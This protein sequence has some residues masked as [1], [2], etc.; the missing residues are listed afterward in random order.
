MSIRQSPSLALAL[1]ALSTGQLVAATQETVHVRVSIEAPHYGVLSDE[2]RAGVE[3]RLADTLIAL[4]RGQYPFLEWTSAPP[5]VPRLDVRL[6][7]DT[8]V[9]PPA[10]CHP[11]LDLRFVATT[12]SGVEN[13]LENAARGVVLFEACDH[14]SFPVDTAAILDRAGLALDSA[15]AAVD[16]R[17]DFERGFVSLVAFADSIEP[18]DTT[19]F[20]SGCESLLLG[21]GSK[22][23]VLFAENS[24]SGET[25]SREFL[26]LHGPRPHWSRSEASDGSPQVEWGYYLAAV[27]QGPLRQLATA[28]AEGRLADVHVFVTEYEKSRRCL[29][30]KQEGIQSD[31]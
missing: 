7:E 4:A 11:K 5:D 12:S 27:S 14:R 3:S 16:V 24:P 29:D 21:G 26:D 31:P 22:L 9:T 15:F 19:L 13:E 6:V 8:R 10:D 18:R 17:R 1:V 20:L 2:A 30:M 25:L 28:A 23:S